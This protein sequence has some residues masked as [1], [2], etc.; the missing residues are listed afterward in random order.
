[1]YRTGRSARVNRA[2]LPSGGGKI[3]EA[4]RQV[5][6]GSSVASP[7]IVEGTMWGAITV[8]TEELPPDTEQRLEKFADLVTTAIANAEGKAELAAS[9]RRI[10]AA[11][12][13]ARRR[14]E[15]DLHDGVQQQLVSLALKLGA[16]EAE[17]PA[18]DALEEQLPSLRGDV[19]SV[20]EGLVEIA[21]GIHPTILAQGGLGAALKGLA[22]RSAV[23]VELDAHLESPLP[24]EVEVAAYYVVSEA[25][26]NVAKYARA[27][28]VHIDVTTDDGTLTLVVRDDG[29]GGA[30]PGKGSGL[31]GLQD[32]VEA[33][34]GTI[35]IDSSARNGTSVVV[36]LPIA[37]EAAEAIEDIGPS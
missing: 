6:I 20:L 3:G 24:D 22:R 1:V 18:A 13:D 35:T 27:S 14:I 23:P 7:I 16:M 15:R 2:E 36:A 26:T 25:L 4:A 29:I 17:L 8:N 34:G 37:T 28:T 32:R 5:G 9:R 30:D 21:R 11:S 31:L 12:D 33:L 19:G 10:I